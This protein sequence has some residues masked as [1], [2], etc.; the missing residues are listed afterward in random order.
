[1]A[2]HWP[3]GIICTNAGILLIGPLG[4]NLSEISIEI[5][6]LSLKKNAF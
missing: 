4:I 1:M 3:G 5:K 6:I 2:L